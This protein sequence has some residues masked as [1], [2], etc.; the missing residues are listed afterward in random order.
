MRVAKT[1]SSDPV[2]RRRPGRILCESGVV[3]G[4]AQ[5]VPVWVQQAKIAQAPWL[6]RY[7]IDDCPSGDSYLFTRRVEVIDL[8]NEFD[9]DGWVSLVTVDY[10]GSQC[11]ADSDLV[12]GES[13][14]GQYGSALIA[15]DREAQHSNVEI[16]GAV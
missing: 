7:F 5:V 3:L 4:D 11:G 6:G 15:D 13:Q 9:T 16:R 10:F 14:V 8:K 12:S 1:Y 2:A